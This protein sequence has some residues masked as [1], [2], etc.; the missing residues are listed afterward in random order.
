[1]NNMLAYV[2]RNIKVVNISILKVVISHMKLK[3]IKHNYEQYA[4]IC[5]DFT[6]HRPLGLGIK[7]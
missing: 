1:M 6:Q 7:V 2:W 4:S 5:F 3:G